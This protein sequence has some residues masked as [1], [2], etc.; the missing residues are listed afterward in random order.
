MAFYPFAPSS[1][2]RATRAATPITLRNVALEPSAPGADSRKPYMLAPT[3]GLVLRARLNDV[4]PRAN[5]PVR[6]LFCDPD[7]RGGALFAVAG[8]RLFAL[9]NAWVVSDLGAID[10]FRPTIMRGFGTEL[11]VKGDASIYFYNG[12]LTT[13]T[14]VDAP[15]SPNTLAVLANRVISSSTQTSQFDWST[16]ASATAWPSD[17]FASVQWSV[18]RGI[19]ETRGYLAIFGTDKMQYWRATGGADADAFD[20]VGFTP[21]DKGLLNR[22]AVA[23]ADGGLIW[24]AADFAMYQAD[25]AGLPQR[26]VNRD[27]EIALE[28]LTSDQLLSVRVFTYLDGSRLY[29]VV[30]PPVGSARVYD[31]AF[32]RWHERTTFGADVYAPGFYARAFNEHVVASPDSSEIWSWDATVYTDNG[33]PI[34]RVATVHVP[35]SDPQSI[36]SVILDAQFIGQ[37]L[38]GQGSAPVIMMRFSRDGGMTWSSS[39]QGI[40]RT[41]GAPGAGNYKPHVKFNRLGRFA[42]SHGL[43][44]EFTMTEPIGFSFYGVWVNE[45]PT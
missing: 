35:L 27:L 32:E 3:P 22:D 34:E 14:D 39:L 8:D 28:S 36:D 30:R 15:P 31:A 7:V 16:V 10:G 24:I 25:G 4:E 45:D 33:Q 26:V 19:V 38:E 5:R 37:P 12:T 18:I 29:A 2:N 41:T 44:L 21:L 9:N 11:V 20:V 1:D 17:G 43:L 42:G 6:A 23:K 13:V 40:I